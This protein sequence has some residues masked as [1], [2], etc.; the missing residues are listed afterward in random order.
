MNV[1]GATY[2]RQKNLMQHLHVSSPYKNPSEK[3]DFE[4]IKNGSLF[5]YVQYDIEKPK[6]QQENFDNIPPV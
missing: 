5:S 2:S 1:I 3:K 6:N 4:N